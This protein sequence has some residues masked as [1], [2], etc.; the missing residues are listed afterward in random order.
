[1]ANLTIKNVPDDLYDQ[2]KRRADEN[3]RSLNNEVIYS[4]QRVVRERRRDVRDILA[5][6][7][8]LRKSVS[9]PPLTDE[10]LEQAIDEGRS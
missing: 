6:V 10:M 4:L 3:R 8:A 1:M 2:L 7:D 9:G 5:E